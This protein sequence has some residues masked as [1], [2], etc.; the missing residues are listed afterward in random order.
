MKISDHPKMA[1]L[2]GQ[3]RP[4]SQ[5]KSKAIKEASPSAGA[6]KGIVNS[7]D[8]VRLSAKARDIQVAQKS[9]E[10]VPDVRAEKVDALKKQI[11]AGTYN[12]KGESIADGIIKA[13]LLDKKV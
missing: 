5:E 8:N 12:V 11:A 2:E 13:S 3:V 4:P 1:N 6:E 10:A 7:A 9:L